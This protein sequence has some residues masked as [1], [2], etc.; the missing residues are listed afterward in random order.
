VPRLTSSLNLRGGWALIAY[1]SA[2][3]SPYYHPHY[4][5]PHHDIIIYRYTPNVRESLLHAMGIWSAM[6]FGI[7][8]EPSAVGR[9]HFCRF[10]TATHRTASLAWPRGHYD[11][12]TAAAASASA[13]AYKT[14]YTR[15]HLLRFTVDKSIHTAPPP[16]PSGPRI[17]VYVVSFYFVF[18][19]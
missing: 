14:N 17:V 9:R 4:T 2:Y 18:A 19:V 8:V 10:V 15:A 12:M 11:N 16:P 13:V 1:A 7:V 5:H 3:V 6:G